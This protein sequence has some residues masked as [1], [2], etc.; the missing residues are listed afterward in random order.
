MKYSQRREIV[1]TMLDTSDTLSVQEIVAALGASEATVRRD[2]AR[3]E[4]EGALVRS[5]GGVHRAD[6]PEN[7]RKRTLETRRPGPE[8]LAMGR[9]AAS[10]VRDGD[11]IYVGAGIST[12]AMI[13]YIV[14]RNVHAVTNGIPQ[15]EA[16]NRAGID[17]LLLCGF[18]KEYSR[19]LVGR[20]TVEML[21]RYRF[22][23][24]FMGA[25]GLSEDL[26]I[27]SGDAYEAE[28]KSLI[29]VG[30]ERSYLLL[31]HTKYDRAAFYSTSR[32]EARDAIVITD[33]PGVTSPSWEA[34]GSGYVSRLGDIVRIE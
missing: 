29:L 22:D 20:E 28:I 24:A 21:A 11:T 2:I 25:H 15:L 34:V 7:E 9:I 16:L 5:W 23:C 6:T 1:L 18:F 31:D 17:T 33:H 19:S 27:L 3:M 12:L 32:E 30:S 4:Q 26:D 13:P 10:Y 8:H 14:A